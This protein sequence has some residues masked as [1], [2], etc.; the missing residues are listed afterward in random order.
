M[1]TLVLKVKFA[2]W[3]KYY[4]NSVVMFCLL[5]GCEPDMARVCYWA[6]RALRFRIKKE[7]E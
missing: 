7:G 4:L 2:W 3:F 5:S 6:N 1:A